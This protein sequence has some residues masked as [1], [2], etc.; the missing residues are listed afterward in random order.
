MR[1][2]CRFHDAEWILKEKSPIKELI[3]RQK[4]ARIDFVIRTPMLDTRC[5]SLTFLGQCGCG[6]G[7]VDESS[8]K[9]EE[10]TTEWLHFLFSELSVV[11][12]VKVFATSH[13]FPNDDQ[14]FIKQGASQS[15]LI[16]R[17]RIT[18]MAQEYWGLMDAQYR[19]R[20]PALT[21]RVF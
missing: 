11:K 3:A 20:I 1:N 15:L 18:L 8:R 5:G 14:L 16:D 21:S 17:I 7:D 2:V 19:D 6:K 9:S 12:P 4:D 13:H 10:M